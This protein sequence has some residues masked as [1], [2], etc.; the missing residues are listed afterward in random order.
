MD[1]NTLKNGLYILIG[2]I[3]VIILYNLWIFNT[4]DMNN[5]KSVNNINMD[6]IPVENFDMVSELAKLDSIQK[7]N[8]LVEPVIMESSSNTYEVDLGLNKNKF[9]KQIF[10][11]V[12]DED[13]NAGGNVKRSIP[14]DLQ[15]I[16]K[17]GDV[18]NHVDMSKYKLITTTNNDIFYSG[19]SVNFDRLTDKNGE[20]VKGNKIILK[21][22]TYKF[23]FANIYVFG[24]NTGVD[25]VPMGGERDISDKISVDTDTGKLSALTPYLISKIEFIDNGLSDNAE[26]F[27]N[28][29]NDNNMNTVENFK[30]L[31]RIK[32]LKIYK[33]SVDGIDK[34]KERKKQLRSI[35]NDSNYYINDDTDKIANDIDNIIKY[36]YA[37]LRILR[38][39]KIGYIHVK[40]STLRK[41]K[42]DLL[43]V[44]DKIKS[45]VLDEITKPEKDYIEK[46]VFALID[47]INSSRS[48]S[49][50]KEEV[51]DPLL[52]N[53]NGV[54]IQFKNNYADILGIET[55][56]MLSDEVVATEEEL[57]ENIANNSATG[58]VEVELNTDE[59]FNNVEGFAGNTNIYDTT[60][61]ILAPTVLTYYFEEPLLIMNELTDVKI[62]IP[63]YK[64][65]KKYGK[66]ASNND[67]QNFKFAN[68]LISFRDSL[69][70]DTVLG[71]RDILDKVGDSMEILDVLDYQKKINSQLKQLDLN[72]H[73]IKD[74]YKQKVEIINTINKIDRISNNY[75]KQIKDADAH[76]ANKFNETIELLQY[77]KSELN[78]QANLEKTKFDINLHL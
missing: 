28:M 18:E 56:L 31:D 29:V 6:N 57:A 3:I 15:I 32:K 58:T 36:Y 55:D 63:G 22:D 45:K 73:N 14:L 24:N 12:I 66:P 11:I 21:S 30:F 75:L 13:D 9:I 2:I 70:P 54:L 20:L 41:L 51:L 78:K 71:D 16:V 33:K 48:W 53:T 8:L 42:R 65:N 74:L 35:K 19:K 10:I 62:V 34:L 69:N 59:G 43:K 49:K 47:N 60:E 26:A 39:K 77:L 50:Q 68:G 23:K 7:Y 25:Y 72:K 37:Q 52:N 38:I 61:I 1:R 46:N 40:N 44:K 64:I 5:G 67:I 76:N 4:N 17:D 27:N